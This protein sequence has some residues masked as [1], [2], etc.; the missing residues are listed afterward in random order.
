MEGIDCALALDGEELGNALADF[1]LDLRE[2]RMGGGD[3]AGFLS[4]EV[5]C[6]GRR[7]HE[8]TIGQA[9]HEGGGTEAVRAVVG[10]IRFAEDVEAGDVGH[11]VIVNP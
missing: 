7:N 3:G 1:A 11:Q 6:D 2:G 8:I 9:L 4:S 10:E 5:V